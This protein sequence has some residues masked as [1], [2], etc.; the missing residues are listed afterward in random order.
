MT[1]KGK[2]K[3]HEPEM[4]KKKNS[5]TEKQ[6]EREKQSTRAMLAQEARRGRG[7]G[8]AL[9]I[10]ERETRQ[11]SHLARRG[12]ETHQVILEGV[13]MEE[14]TEEQIQ[15]MDTFHKKHQ[16]SMFAPDSCAPHA[17]GRR[18]P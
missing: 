17:S 6:Q 9:M 4:K 2:E 12:E 5:R 16:T 3:A 18:G 10:I 7:H 14:Y 15:W 11:S 8:G 1:Q 13:Q